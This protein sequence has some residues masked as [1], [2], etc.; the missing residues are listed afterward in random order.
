MKAA[1]IHGPRDIRVEAV[2]RPAI[3]NDEVLVKVRAC[4]ICGTDLHLY[5]TGDAPNKILG[6]EW[7][8]EVAEIGSDIKG[9]NVGDRVAGV[10]YRIVGKQ[11]NVPGE[12]LDG[13]FAEYV[14]VPK[15]LVGNSFLKLPQSLSWELAAT[16]EPV[17]IACFVVEQAQLQPKDTIVI[18]G[19]GMIGQCIV[20]I[21]KNLGVSKII[22]FEPSSKR[23]AMASEMGANEALNPLETDPVKAVEKATTGW[24]ANVIF[25]CSGV[26]TSLFKA[27]QMTRFFGRIMQIGFFEQDIALSAELVNRLTTYRNITWRGCGGQKWDMALDMVNSGKV[28]TKKLIT[29]QF[30]LDRIQE[31]FNAQLNADE[32]IKVL[33]K[34]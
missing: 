7:S 18:F 33:V 32:A 10:G 31:A 30:P 14:A 3:Q 19:A 21:C 13:A 23:R 8:G 26:P 24:M 29:H 4:G 2:D 25:E 20:Q 16:I 9:L 34:L 17:S 22:V 15:P 11:V 5:K 28:N 27:I 6:H 12:G 1:I